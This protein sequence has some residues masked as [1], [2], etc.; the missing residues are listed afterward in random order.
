MA[1]AIDTELTNINYS[2]TVVFGATNDPTSSGEQKFIELD[3]MTKAQQQGEV[4]FSYR[5]V[6]SDTVRY[7][8]GYVVYHNY[9]LWIMKTLAPA[10]GYAPGNTSPYWTPFGNPPE[11]SV[12][13]ISRHFTLYRR[14]TETNGPDLTDLQDDAIYTAN[15]WNGNLHGA[16]VLLA[17]QTG[18]DPLWIITGTA[19]NDGDG[20]A[21][22]NWQTHP[23]S[24]LPRFSETPDGEGHYPAT[25]TDQYVRYMQP[26]GQWTPWLPYG[27]VAIDSAVLDW[28]NLYYSGAS[29]WTSNHYTH[30]TPF[31]VSDY[32]EYLFRF[33]SF[34]NWNM[35][36]SH[37]HNLEYDAEAILHKLGSLRQIYVVNN[38]LWNNW[39][40]GCQI[41]FR[42]TDSG[43]SVSLSN[44][45]PSGST[46]HRQEF[47]IM[48]LRENGVTTGDTVHYVHAKRGI[49]YE[50]GELWIFG[51]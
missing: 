19:R 2:N 23:L 37:E 13:P 9:R 22:Q 32:K 20:W 42:A 27:E 31:R 3:N 40:E 35:A 6:Y 14:T 18:T 39:P 45:S 30:I 10:A 28:T 50:R 21:T 1:R 43:G 46:D 11:A 51:R 44:K 15:G 34:Q 5:G 25:A 33:R 12:Y 24:L 7:A 8:I 49:D 41:F 17:S 38:A 48:F 36:V 26:G 29:S 4:L 16:T 47:S